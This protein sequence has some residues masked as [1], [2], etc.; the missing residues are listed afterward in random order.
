MKA[1]G[2]RPV[3]FE[4]RAIVQ[5]ETR[6]LDLTP[7]TYDSK[8]RTVQAILSKGTPVQQFY[9]TE[10]LQ[11][12]SAAVD[13]SRIYTSGIPLLDSHKQDGIGNALGRATSAWIDSGALMG[14][15]TFNETSEARKA[16]GMVARGEITGISIGYRVA[17]W[18]ITDADGDVVDPDIDRH[19]FT[20]NDLTF[21]A[22]KWE[23]LEVSLVSVPADAAA[24]IRGSNVD[25]AYSCNTNA[26]VRA[27]MRI[28]QRMHDRH[29]ALLRA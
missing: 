26:D 11:I 13:L 3:D 2:H 23:L 21:T 16:E 24:G 8:T 19:R 17:D 27:R 5:L 14:A 20:D 15:I 9:G 4:R 12:S 1:I 22:S 18:T 6:L 25:R 7:S 29:R 28:R 10:K